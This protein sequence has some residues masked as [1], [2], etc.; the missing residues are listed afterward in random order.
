MSKSIHQRFAEKCEP[1]PETDC[2]EWVGARQPN[3]YGRIYW[4]RREDGSYRIVFA[5]RAAWEMRHG[6]IP[7]GLCVLHRCDNRGCVNPDHLFLGTHADNMADMDAK[8]R[9][10]RKGPEGIRARSA[11][12]DDDRV[13]AIRLLAG[14][15]S[16]GAIGRRFGVDS[17]TVNHILRGRT[18]KH[19][20]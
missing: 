6:E 20:V 13:R 2:I 18:W 9:R 3:G 12:L 16:Q 4:G 14:T 19:V 15:M 10:V 8:G 5:H 17:A 1:N 11:I 7:E